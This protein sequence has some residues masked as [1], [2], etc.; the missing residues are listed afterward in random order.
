MKIT[1]EKSVVKKDKN[2]N[3]GTSLKKKI[4]ISYMIVLSF[5]LIIASV[6]VN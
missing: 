6:C 5:M 3:K 2:K 1:R 4:I